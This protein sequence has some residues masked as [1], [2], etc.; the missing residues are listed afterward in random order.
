M[1]QKKYIQM[2]ALKEECK[3]NKIAFAKSATKDYLCDVLGKYLFESKKVCRV[4]EE[5]GISFDNLKSS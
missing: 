3:E 4:D 2:K 5:K 1:R